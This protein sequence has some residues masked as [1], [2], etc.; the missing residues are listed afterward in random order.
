MCA[1]EAVPRG[2][3]QVHEGRADIQLVYILLCSVCSAAKSAAWWH[4]TAHV[5]AR[6]RMTAGPSQKPLTAWSTCGSLQAPSTMT[7]R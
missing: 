3:Q 2:A 7:V 1:A 6:R 4:M 5:R